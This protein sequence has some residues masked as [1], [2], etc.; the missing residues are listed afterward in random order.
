MGNPPPRRRPRIF[1][2]FDGFEDEDEVEPG[3]AAFSD[4][5]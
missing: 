5:L 1:Q 4:S 3:S 2:S